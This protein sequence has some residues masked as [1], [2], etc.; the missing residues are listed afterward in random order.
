MLVI[1][2]EAIPRF[3]EIM[4]FAA[5]NDLLTQLVDQ[6]DYLSSYANREGCRYDINKG[7]NTCCTLG[8]DFAP[9]SMSISMECCET[10]YKDPELHARQGGKWEHWWIGGLI[11]QGPT[12]PADGSAPSLTVSLDPCKHGWGIHT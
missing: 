8:M 6:L 11:Y 5:E 4:K 2:K 10:W 9:M 1:D 12:Q 3:L 7:K